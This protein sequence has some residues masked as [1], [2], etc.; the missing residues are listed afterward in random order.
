MTEPGQ[1]RFKNCLSLVFLVCCWEQVSSFCISSQCW[2][3]GSASVR[4]VQDIRSSVLHSAYNVGSE[5]CVVAET[6]NG[7]TLVNFLNQTSSIL[8]ESVGDGEI[9]PDKQN[10]PECHSFAASVV[11]SY[12]LSGVLIVAVDSLVLEC[13][14][15]SPVWLCLLCG[16]P[17][18]S[19]SFGSWQP[20]VCQESEGS[21]TQKA[22]FPPPPA[23]KLHASY[24]NFCKVWF[25]SAVFSSY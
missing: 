10:K 23:P 16:V 6:N 17:S 20:G 9:Q 25:Y 12:C 22:V 4:M 1:K 15:A 11:H 24:P 13:P 3:T 14:A 5:G 21:L 19:P 18:S 8:G 7:Q 2:D